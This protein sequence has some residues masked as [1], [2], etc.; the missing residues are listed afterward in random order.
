[1]R[2]PTRRL[3]LPELPVATGKDRPMSETPKIEPKWQPSEN[4]YAGFRKA[5]E[6][7]KLGTRKGSDIPYI[8]H[9]LGVASAVIEAGG[10]EDQAIAAFLHD[11]VEDTDVSVAEIETEFG[12]DVARIVDACTDATKEQKDAEKK[13]MAK[14]IQDIKVKY[15]WPRKSIYIA[16]LRE[17]TMD[18]P[19][20]LVALADKTYNA[21]NT[22]ADLRGK[23]D[24]EREEVWSKFNVGVELQRDWYLGL[25]E[26][27]KENKTY[28]KFSQPLFNRFEA[29]VNEIFPNNT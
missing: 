7:H 15:W 1:V 11:M 20:V 9:L 17:K 12:K 16:K 13:E 8:G 4:F 28:D 26:A 24:D 21:E 19:S 22:S 14:E 18:D 29:A 3:D 5:G 2:D 27:F 23:N 6:G 10:T 25:L